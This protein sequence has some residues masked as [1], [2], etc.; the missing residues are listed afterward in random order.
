MTDHVNEIV[1]LVPAKQDVFHIR[2]VSTDSAPLT[3]SLC[4]L[5]GGLHK[6]GWGY[7]GRS[8]SE[9]RLSAL[10]ICFQDTNYPTLTFDFQK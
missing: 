6:P 5:A 2:V 10:H 4:P 1:E 8:L 3:C 7:H 9:T